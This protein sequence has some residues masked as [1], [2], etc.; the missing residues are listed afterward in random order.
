MGLL[1]RLFG[2]DE[3]V[4]VEQ[5]RPK[6]HRV[7]EVYEDRG[8]KWRWRVLAVNG[9]TVGA[10]GEA[11]HSE[12]NALRAANLEASFYIEGTVSVKVRK[13]VL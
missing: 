8:G 10:S 11:F 2:K 1:G 7:F 5:S 4:V 12:G 13:D 6:S 3:P 9:A